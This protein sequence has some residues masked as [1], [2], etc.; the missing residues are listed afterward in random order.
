MAYF[1]RSFSPRIVKRVGKS[2]PQH[3]EDDIVFEF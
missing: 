3:D 2:P 1:F